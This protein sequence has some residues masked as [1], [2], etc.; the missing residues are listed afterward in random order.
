MRA[1]SLIVLGVVFAFAFAGRAAV[2]AASVG[3]QNEATPEQTQPPT[4]IDGPLAE[5][6]AKE[7]ADLEKRKTALAEKDESLQAFARH[8]EQRL[9]ELEKLNAT[10]AER[11]EAADVERVEEV[12]RVATIYEQMKP[13][14]AGPI[15]GSMDPDFAASLLLAMNGERASEVMATLEAKR[16]YAITVLMAGK[17]QYP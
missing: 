2:L 4:C 3:A 12:R 17:A 8:V 15:I 10:L 11:A 5:T 14:Q 7:V 9:V 16:A 1:K 13:A 6:L